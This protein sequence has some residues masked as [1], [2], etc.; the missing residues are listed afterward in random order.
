MVI[1]KNQYQSQTHIAMIIGFA[2]GINITLDK[3]NINDTIL[4]ALSKVV[5][6]LPKVIF[7]I[8]MLIIFIS[9]GFFIVSSS[10]LAVLSMPVLTPLGDNV[11]IGRNV[12]VNA[13]TFGQNYI[14]INS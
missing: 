8:I 12:I 5:D 6:G 7:I 3:G 11:S 14:Q 10:G 2:R 13:Y 9:L 4:F 1:L